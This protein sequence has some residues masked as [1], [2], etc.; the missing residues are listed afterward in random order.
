MF[1][2]V[3]HLIM[4]CVKTHGPEKYILLWFTSEKKKKILIWGKI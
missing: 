2:N 3:K 4:V 1:I